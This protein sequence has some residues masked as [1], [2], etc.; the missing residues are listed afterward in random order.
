MEKVKIN[1]NSSENQRIKGKFVSREVYTC[2]SYEMDEILKLKPELFDDI[3]NL[4]NYNCTECGSGY[5]DEINAKICCLD[6]PEVCPE[7]GEKIGDKKEFIAEFGGVCKCGK[8]IINVDGVDDIESEP[9]EVFEWWIISKWLYEKL[10]EKGEP[11]LEWG[12]NYYWGRTTMGQAILLD[13]I[14]SDICQD[15]EIL[16]GQKNSLKG[17]I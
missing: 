3:E 5:I 11:V 2:F 1:P 8:E 12:N 4:Y 10:K 16:D 15:M 14:I 7:C 6:V 9:Q 13:W 17:K